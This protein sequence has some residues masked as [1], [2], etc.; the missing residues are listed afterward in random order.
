M[1]TMGKLMAGAALVA[2][3]SAAHAQDLPD[4]VEAAAS[5]G[6]S[7]TPDR[8]VYA[9]EDFARFAP[10]SALDMVQQIPGFSIE[11]DG[12]GNRNR[13]RGLGQANGNVL[14]NGE[15]VVT[16]ADSVSDQLA[17]IPAEDVIRIELV[18]GS[19]L[20]IP[21]LSGRVANVVAASSDGLSGQFEWNP[22]LA[23]EYA[24]NGWLESNMSLSGTF[25]G[26]SFTAALEGRP[27][28]QGNG[29]PNFLTFANGREE[30]RFSLFKANGNDKRVSGS[31]R[32]DTS[33]GTIANLNASYLHRRFRSFEDEYVVAPASAL[34]LSERFDQRNRGF[35]L[36]LGGDLDFA[37]GPGRLKLIGLNTTQELNFTTQT[38]IDPATGD[39]E[40]GSRFIQQSD[41]GERIGR[42][43]YTWS[44]LGGDWQWSVEAAFNSLDQVGDLFVLQPTGEF[45]PVPFPA[46]TGGVREDRY[47]SLLSYSRMLVDGLSVQLIAGGEYS[48]IRQTGAAANART[49]QRPKGTLTVSWTPGASTDVTFKV[50]RRVGQLDFGDFLAEVDLNDDNQNAANNELRPDQSWGVELEAT[51]DFGAWGSASVRAFRRR[52]EDFVTIVPTPGG[53]EARGNVEFATI[54]GVQ[55]DGT[56]QLTPLGLPGAKIDVS[57]RLRD[58]RYP[59]PVENRF[60]PVRF[61]EPH[62]IELDFR[63]DI[64]GSNWAWGW[65]FRDTGFNRYYRV[66]EEGLDYAIDRNLAL[67]LEH[68]DVFGLTVKGRVGNLLEREVVLDRR[69]FAG[70]RGSSPLLFSEN[71]R[72]EVGRV[73]ELSVKGSF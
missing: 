57:G 38:V 56:L 35:D 10:R 31:V 48:S 2:L 30:E 19:T 4:A 23:A 12:G 25:G 1:S 65:D 44:M 67:F 73:L 55:L 3:S 13:S 42:G 34:P 24:E 50:D 70:P 53:G 32:Y 49:F 43:E 47:E 61:A 5:D 63:H 58:S 15:R 52:F 66:A 29:G 41:R 72:R 20:N 46:G 28:R 26:F 18:E 59:D 22:Q 60:L 64:P 6:S 39:P 11:G 7:I 36:E 21:G 54:R 45:Q 9:A 33:G 17:R 40:F 14:L 37:L 69:V 71:R 16:K 8:Q 62:N 51:R 27:F 68:K